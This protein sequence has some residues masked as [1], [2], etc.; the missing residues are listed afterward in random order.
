MPDPLA[1]KPTLSLTDSQQ[2]VAEVRG[3]FDRIRG[4]VA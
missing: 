3:A 1:S 2:A 4:E